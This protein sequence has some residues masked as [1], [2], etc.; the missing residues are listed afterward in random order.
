MFCNTTQSKKRTK[1]RII[2]FR[3]GHNGKLWLI[4]NKSLALPN[5]F[6]S[7]F[8]FYRLNSQKNKTHEIRD[9]HF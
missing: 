6:A 3:A 1:T 5:F 7:N 9:L 2:V 8:E 4:I